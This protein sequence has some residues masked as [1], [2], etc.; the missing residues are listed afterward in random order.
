[1]REKVSSRKKLKTDNIKRRIPNLPKSSSGSRNCSK[2]NL[3]EKTKHNGLNDF[4]ESM[5][6]I[7][8]NQVLLMNSLLF[9]D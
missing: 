4:L 2:I 1:M 6:K 7:I 8:I 5:N 9:L 3:N